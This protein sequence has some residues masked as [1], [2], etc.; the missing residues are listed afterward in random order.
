MLQECLTQHIRSIQNR[1]IQKRTFLVLVTLIVVIP[2]VAMSWMGWE[3]WKLAQALRQSSEATSPVPHLS[4][5]HRND[6]FYRNGI[7]EEWELASPH[8]IIMTVG[9]ES[10]L[11][12][13][14]TEAE[15]R[16]GVGGT[17]VAI[18]EKIITFDE[19]HYKTDCPKAWR[20]H[21]HSKN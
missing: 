17:K 19:G 20:E 7:L 14:R 21:G 16:V 1:P 4:K 12:M 11:V 2:M 18:P 3:T 9:I 13:F 6:C 15:R 10:Y 8:G 5:F